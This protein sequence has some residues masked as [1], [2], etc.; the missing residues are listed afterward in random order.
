MV[1]PTRKESQRRPCLAQGGATARLL[2]KLTRP[3]SGLAELWPRSVYG[4]LLLLG[5]ALALAAWR[6][7]PGGTRSGALQG[8]TGLMG[9]MAGPAKWDSAEAF[10]LVRAAVKK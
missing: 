1:P 4:A 9:A 2:H 3:D 6:G 5:L 7:P 8:A 10:D